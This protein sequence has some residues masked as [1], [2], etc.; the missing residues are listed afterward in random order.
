MRYRP[1]IQSSSYTSRHHRTWD[2]YVQRP[3]KAV[4]ATDRRGTQST[5]FAIPELD[6]RTLLSLR[7][8]S[9]AWCASATYLLSKHFLWSL[10]F[11]LREHLKKA[12]EAVACATSSA[13]SGSRDEGEDMV[14][15]NNSLITHAVRRL[16]VSAQWTMQTFSRTYDLDL[17]EYVFNF[18]FRSRKVI[19]A[20]DTLP[21]GFMPRLTIVNRWP[22]D[23]EFE[24]N[25]DIYPHYD[26][27]NIE[28]CLRY[29]K[30]W[31]AVK[32]H[33]KTADHAVLRRVFDNLHSVEMLELYLPEV[34]STY[35]NGYESEAKK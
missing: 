3:E 35:R 10:N 9:R 18:Y 1:E 19:Q 31:K 4:Q 32:H 7:L 16:M 33:D 5:V 29:P 27:M 12:Q 22:N 8:V 26:H 14:L 21:Y 2:W 15:T 13:G 28:G 23:D 11:D 25:Y 30:T 24:E 20:C 17:P 6:Y 34:W